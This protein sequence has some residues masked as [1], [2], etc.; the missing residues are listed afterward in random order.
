MSVNI[1]MILLS[2]KMWDNLV[3]IFKKQM[4]WFQYLMDPEKVAN[5]LLIPQYFDL[6]IYTAS[7]QE[8]VTYNYISIKLLVLFELHQY[9]ILLILYGFGYASVLFCL[10]KKWC[11]S[12]HDLS[13]THVLSSKMILKKKI[14]CRKQQQNW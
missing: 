3:E 4:I 12:S 6:D 5:L 11:L 10:V 13:G 7:R 9:T 8:K 2:L 14:L 1:C